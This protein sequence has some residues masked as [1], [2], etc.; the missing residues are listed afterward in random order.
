MPNYPDAFTLWLE[1]QLQHKKTQCPPWA[2][3]NP[4]LLQIAQDYFPEIPLSQPEQ[5]ERPILNPVAILPLSA[6]P[7]SMNQLEPAE[8]V[9][10]GGPP[11][12]MVA[13]QAALQGKKSLYISDLELASPG[14][15]IR[16]IWAG[17][18]NHGEADVATEGPAY[19]AGYYPCSFIGKELLGCLRPKRFSKNPL[20]PDYPWLSLNLG[21]W[22]R[23][24]HQWLTGLRV[25]WGNALLAWKYDREIRQGIQPEI[26]RIMEKR[27]R[28][29]G[30]YLENL[31]QNTVNILRK[32]R[33]SLILAC[34][35]KQ[36]ANLQGLRENLQK[37]GQQLK[38][39]SPEEAGKKYGLIPRQTVGMMEK[40]HDFIFEADFLKRI[41]EHIKKSGGQVIPHRRLTRV[42]LD[43][44]NNTGGV[45]EFYEL[46]A[47]QEKI[48]HYQKFSQAHLSLGAT[49][50]T[51]SVYDLIS[52]TG[53]SINAL[54]IGASLHG[55]PLV[56]GGTNHVVPLLEPR[57]VPIKDAQG[58]HISLPV[59]FVRL[60][61]GA[62]IGPLDRGKYWY[63]YD[64]CH[65]LHLI[66][67]VRESLPQQFKL[68]IL[69]VTGCNRVIGKDGHQVEIHPRLQIN[70]KDFI[71]E[72]LTI[73]IGAGGGGL[74]QM[75]ALPQQMLN[76]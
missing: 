71:G 62:S 50:F 26:I 42:F 61:T 41:S 33:G 39:L 58:Q 21:E 68:H 75:G 32:P 64:G 16:P 5:L 40:T 44:E 6:C 2:T 48:F 73:Q 76:K 30:Q 20:D 13:L 53:V 31:N 29:S 72:R 52:V 66:H 69:S 51:P 27:V 28:D 7:V 24:P 12:A 43:T 17:A 47:S 45:L 9:A 22:L 35:P 3:Q 74:T 63:Y 55:G 36:L 65:A 18:G 70:G 11:A 54:L 14:K 4:E 49:P 60:S 8:L 37:H 59:S 19:L 46:N 1:E 67:R 57:M 56:C 10:V 23:N 38:S 25:F 34:T 15:Q